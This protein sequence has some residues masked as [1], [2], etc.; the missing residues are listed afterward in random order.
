L[1]ACC[2]LASGELH[3]AGLDG[4]GAAARAGGGASGGSGAAASLAAAIA[5][6]AL[7]GAA[8]SSAHV[9]GALEALHPKL[10]AWVCARDA[11]AAAEG[12]TAPSAVPP[13]L[14]AACLSSL[15]R[16][17]A[18]LLRSAEPPPPPA[19]KRPRY[20]D[21]PAE[22][23]ATLAQ[24]VEARAAEW[25]DH[26]RRWLC[27]WERGGRLRPLVLR[28]LRRH[29]V[30]GEAP[31]AEGSRVHRLLVRLAPEAAALSA[32]LGEGREPERSSVRA[33]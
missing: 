30:L 5:L 20:L 25:R 10:L 32:A 22:G 17:A 29:A 16:R 23:G 24:R 19:G 33:R 21:G 26:A 31:S 15:Q 8:A 2:W 4:A 9:A 13:P 1:Q 7:R 3:A 18:S 27:L 28:E 11:E 12:G 14:A 6:T